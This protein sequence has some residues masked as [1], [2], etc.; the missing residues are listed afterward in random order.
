MDDADA[1]GEGGRSGPGH[2]QLAI[3][4]SQVVHAPTTGDVV[5]IAPMPAHFIA[6]RP[7]PA[8]VEA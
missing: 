7:A 2:V 5:R 3:S 8:A 4:G 6:R 1:F